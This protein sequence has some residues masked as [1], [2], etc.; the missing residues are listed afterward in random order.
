VW[1]YICYEIKH[2]NNIRNNSRNWK[3]GNSDD[4]DD[5]DDDDPADDDNNNTLNM[6]NSWWTMQLM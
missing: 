3:Q 6:F 4:D 5:D 1:F 2:F